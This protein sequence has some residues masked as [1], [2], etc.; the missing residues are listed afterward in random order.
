MGFSLAPTLI[1]LVGTCGVRIAWLYTAFA[2][3]PT[4]EMLFIGYPVSWALSW[5]AEVVYYRRVAPRVL[6][7]QS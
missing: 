4:W 2:L 6:D 3:W 5:L 7:W 1:I